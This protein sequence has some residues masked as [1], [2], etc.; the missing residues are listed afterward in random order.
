MSKTLLVLAAS[1]YQLP[2]IRTAKR[3]GYRVLT[4]DNTPANPGHALADASFNVDTTDF[5]A[6]LDLAIA[7][8]IS[9][10]IAPA[11]DVAIET[12]AY[13]SDN[14][15]L[16]GPSLEAARI[17]TRKNLFR[18][19]LL[20]RGLP[21]PRYH[22]ILTS[23]LPAQDL[24]NNRQW[25]IKPNRSSGSKGVF[26]LR[27]QAEFF[28]RVCE[29]RAQ[30]LD[31]TAILEAFLAGTQHS[32]DGV[33]EDGF[34]RLALVTDRATAAPPHTATMGHV[35][36]SR[37][38]QSRQRDAVGAIQ[39]V[40]NLLGVR[41]GPFDCDFVVDH[42]QITLIEMTPRLGG[43]SL[44][45]LMR[46][47]LGFDVT[48]YAVRH[49]C[50]DRPSAPEVRNPRPAA[51]IILGAE[52]AGRL[53]WNET[54]VDLLRNEPWVDSLTL[55]YSYRASVRPFVDGRGRVGE[56]L[57]VG[58]SRQEV[59]GRAAELKDRLALTVQ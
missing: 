44:C 11:T 14:L 40:F 48:E 21:C 8:N 3:L 59:V 57:I 43:N 32:C 23:E 17:L 34:V 12:V 6:I 5:D 49:A 56:A 55:D 52:R 42:G 50:G 31:N 18:N 16:P 58:A 41:N 2:V 7:Q 26:I 35:V 25:V 36:P 54:E 13:V 53:V 46:A 19:F 39:R 10:I 30:S 1:L 37:L 45:S 51:V 9:G 27:D 4:T 20:E 24:F 15:G 47:A 29:S 28:A 38:P 22:P 33:L